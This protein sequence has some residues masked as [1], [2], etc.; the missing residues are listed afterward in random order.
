MRSFTLPRLLQHRAEAV[1]QAFLQPPG[2]AAVDFA[3]PPGEPGLAGPDSVSWQVFRNPV[4]LFVGGVA[5]VV[6]ELAEP[7]VRSGVWEHSSFRSDPVERLRRTGL[8]AMV[9][10]YAA[11][12]VAER[13][14]A[15]IRRSHSAVAGT[16]PAG[17]P[18]RAD[19]PELLAWVQATAAF[20]FLEAHCAYVSNLGLLDRDRLY[21]EG[22]PAADLYGAAGAP[23]STADMNALFRR[24]RPRL[25]PSPVVAE[26]LGIVQRAPLL[27]PALSAA[28][29]I[30]VRAG[31][32]IVPH[33]VRD[34]VGLGER[35]RLDPWERPLVKGVA[36]I[37][38]R[39]RLDAAPPAQACV[40]MGLP[41]DYLHRRAGG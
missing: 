17:E 10:V 19:D 33:W 8:A 34:I 25:E 27:P 4:T 36:R 21:A 12:G 39:Y 29:N 16:T 41:P 30:L 40:R 31:V 37:A 9:T 38:D 23:Q 35:W 6:L 32:E 22:A 28:Q 20:G 15:G 13:M 24:M 2:A 18:Y 1:A 3:G 5:A 7:R 14:I 11:R 26:F